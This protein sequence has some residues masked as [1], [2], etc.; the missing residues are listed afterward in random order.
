MIEVIVV[1]SGRDT[2]REAQETSGA[3]EMFYILTW[4]VL[5]QQYTYVT[6]KTGHLMFVYFV[7]LYVIFHF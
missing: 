3:P 4:M 6:S 7:H 2:D 1:V 5:T